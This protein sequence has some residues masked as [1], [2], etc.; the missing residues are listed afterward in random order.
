MLAS[1]MSA[2]CEIKEGSCASLNS[3]K[4]RLSRLAAAR[5]CK[6]LKLKRLNV[7]ESVQGHCRT[8]EPI[9]P[10]FMRI[11]APREPLGTRASG[12]GKF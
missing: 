7:P 10:L 2:V 4:V 3:A 11:Y 5:S 9:H 12:A 8:R 6:L 1:Q